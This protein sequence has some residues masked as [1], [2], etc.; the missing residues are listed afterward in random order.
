MRAKK[1]SGFLDCH[2]HHVA[3]RLFVVEHFERLRVVT[4]PTA[5]LARHQR[6]RQKIHL[7]FDHALALA[8]FATAA[9]GIE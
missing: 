6:L 1:I 7:Q 3:D 8:T 9:L 2:L 5:V 4:A